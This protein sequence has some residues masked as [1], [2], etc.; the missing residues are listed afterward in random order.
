MID[1]NGLVDPEGGYN[2]P[3][4]YTDPDLYEL[5][6]D[7]VFGRSW[8]FLAHDSQLP[9]K[10]SFV[11]TYMGEDPVL[12]VRQKDGS[13][14]AFLNQCRHRGMRICR[15]DE[16]VSKT[17]TCSYHGW[18]YD[19][20]GNLVNVPTED[21]A[22][23]NEIDKKN[24]G[25]LKVPRI[26]NYKGFYFGTWSEETP[27]FDEYLGDMAYYFDSVVDRWDNGLEFIGGT[28][29]WVIDCN[30]KFASEQFASDFYHA[31]VAHASAAIALTDQPLV[32][33]PPD[34]PGRQFAGNG[35][36]SGSFWLPEL[37]LP[38]VHV[39]Q[40][41]TAWV[42]E[43][44]EQVY[45]GIGRD[46]AVQVLALHNTVFPNFSWLGQFST[47]RVWHP[48]GLGKME[49]WSWT[50]V[51]KDAPAEVKATIRRGVQR[52]FSPA[53]SFETDDGENWTEIQK[54]LR[55]FKARES[56]FNTQ[57]GLGFEERDTN[58]QPG[59]S[60]DVFAERQP[61]ASIAIGVS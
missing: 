60:N 19:L 37:T 5:E 11:Q 13:V 3:R 32:L 4:I 30:W 56:R 33:L 29:K 39:G 55:G 16:G 6:L 15:A 25:A 14:K 9:K 28:S 1:L 12:V 17:F 59:Q 38:D 8:L 52:T 49:V 53:G 27:E 21:R 47:M 44:Q 41:Y 2:N 10:G 46:R 7:R 26:T 20:E 24:W 61:A 45:G 34:I 31:P 43:N 36:G 54:V 40:K 18:A 22:Y 35:H 58:G 57:M 48:R 42:A 50:F 51:P 23:H